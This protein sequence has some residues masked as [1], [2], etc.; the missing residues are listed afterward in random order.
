MVTI[1]PTWGDEDITHD[2]TY[3][4]ICTETGEH[5]L[6]QMDGVPSFEISLSVAVL[7]LVSHI[8][9]HRRRK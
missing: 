9:N 6:K 2:T 1:Y 3:S 8:I 4:A 7:A 5:S